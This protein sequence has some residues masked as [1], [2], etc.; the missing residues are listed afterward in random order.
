MPGIIDIA[1]FLGKLGKVP[2][3]DVR[4]P[5]E[6]A[7]AHIPGVENLPLF[8]DEERKIVGTLYK[9]KGRETATLRGMDFAGPKMS[10]YVRAAR[11]IAPEKRIM[12]HCWRGGMRSRAMA[13]TLETAGFETYLLEGGYRSFRRMANEYFEQNYNLTVLGGMTG[14]GKT[15][16]LHLLRDKGEQVIDLEG[17]ANHKGSAFGAIGQHSQPSTE[18]FAN[19]LFLELRGMDLEKSLWVEDESHEIGKVGIP[20]PFFL[21]MREAKLA[22]LEIPREIRARR[23]VEEYTGV[24]DHALRDAF[25]RIH[26]RLGG[27]NLQDALEAINKKDYYRAA[28][29]SLQY[30]DKAYRF[31]IS[32][33]PKE[34]VVFIPSGSG[35]ATH[36]AKILLENLK[37]KSVG[38]DQN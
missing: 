37:K 32:K 36:N 38:N 5:S 6:Y 1:E 33:R 9:Q 11:K 2:A 21:Q 20:H 22:C 35:N 29:I 16:I 18:Q 14:S 24:S 12:V 27:Q 23:L 8:D 4:T 26:K 34:N 17:L 7:H 10:A 25:L 31:G 30:Y 13:F 15:E 19:L 28:L 3:I